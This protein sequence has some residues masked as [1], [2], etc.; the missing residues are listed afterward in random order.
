[1]SEKPMY[2][3]HLYNYELCG[4]KY[5]WTHGWGQI[6]L[7]RGPGK[8]RERPVRDSNHHAVMGNVIQGVIEDFYND[9]LW[10]HKGLRERLVRMTQERLTKDLVKPRNK[11][12]YDKISYQ[13]LEKTCIDGVLGYVFQTMKHHRFLSN[14]YAKSE[15]ELLGYMDK[16]LPIAGRADMI[17]RSDDDG[18]VT[19][20][21]GKNSQSKMKY[22]S[23]DQL[24]FYALAYYL[25]YKKLPDRLGF[26]WFRYPYEEGTEEDGV[27]WITFTERDLKSLAD[28]ARDVR[29]K[30]KKELFDPTPVPKNCNF[31]DFESVC[32][33]RIE[34][35]AA[36]SAKRRKNMGLPVVPSG[37][38][39][40]DFNSGSG[41]K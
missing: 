20:L 34:Q 25:S 30:Q 38:T 17:I 13:E 12:N 35:K 16:Y 29:K 28:R 4:Q 18:K 22:L 6:D 10:K 23:P 19:I 32:Q 7:G 8:G 9:Y 36:N 11:V 21:D 40:L 33:A 15:V 24:R 5:L 1:M 27:E 14:S 3:S 31:C 26:V 41:S 37:V 39:V 2:W